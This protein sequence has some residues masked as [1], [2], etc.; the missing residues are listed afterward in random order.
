MSKI[1]LKCLSFSPK[2][3]SLVQFPE[4]YTETALHF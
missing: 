1:I 3:H 2:K 4:A